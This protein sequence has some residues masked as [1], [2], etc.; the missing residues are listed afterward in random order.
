LGDV[1]RRRIQDLLLVATTERGAEQSRGKPSE[2]KKKKE[3]RD[4]K[5]DERRKMCI[6]LHLE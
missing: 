5:M 6:N 4:G 2:K 1:W 3:L